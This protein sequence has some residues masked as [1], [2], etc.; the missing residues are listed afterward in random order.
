MPAA[1][2]ERQRVSEFVNSFESVGG[3]HAFEVVVLLDHGLQRNN[4]EIIV[5]H[6]HQV[7][8]ALVLFQV[9]F[10][11]FLLFGLFLRLFAFFRQ[12]RMQVETGKVF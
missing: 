1:T 8:T 4:V 6:D 2:C 11:L 7:R 10:G 5:V 9:N 12:L 3:C